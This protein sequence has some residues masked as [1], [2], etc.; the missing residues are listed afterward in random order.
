MKKIFMVM[1]L[2]LT[3]SVVGIVGAEEWSGTGRSYFIGDL[4]LL[5][6]SKDTVQVNYEAFGIHVSDSGKG[7]FHNSTNYIVGGASVVKGVVTDSGFYT[8]ILTSGDK[9]FTT[10]NA[11]GKMGMV[12][13][14]FTYVSGTGKATGITGGGEFTRYPLQPPTKGKSASF[15]IVKS[16]YTLP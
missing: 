16:H 1:V 2:L 4:T 7:L 11:S 15:S 13:G 9:V 14:A 12:K 5:P 8:I 3:L 10:Y 6:F